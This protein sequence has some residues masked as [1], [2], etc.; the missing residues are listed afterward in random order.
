MR[1]SFVIKHPSV[2][3]SR[4]QIQSASIRCCAA[5]STPAPPKLTRLQ[6]E[7]QQV[8]AIDVEYAHVLLETGQRL[9]LPVE[10]CIVDWQG[11]TLLRKLC[12]GFDAHS[13]DYNSIEWEF[14]GGV[15]AYEWLSAPSLG[16][17]MPDI[18]AVLGKDR[19][20]VGH[21]VGKDLIA[22]GLDDI[23][24]LHRRRDTMR[25][26]ALQGPTGHGRSLAELARKRLG[27]RIQTSVR[28]DPAE[29]AIAALDLYLKYCHYDPAL[30]QYDD[31]VEYYASQ[32]LQGDGDIASDGGEGDEGGAIGEGNRDGIEN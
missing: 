2:Q 20:V 24:P 28:H 19:P 27:R 3:A 9:Q 11:N 6:R 21:N 8:V 26:S 12:N 13:L 16:S 1:I 14:K 10:V 18:L 25:Y 29:D 15:P 23:V 22:L 31:L 17:I 30:M 7:A 4:L 5:P 32:L